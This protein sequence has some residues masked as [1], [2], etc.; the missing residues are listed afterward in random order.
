MLEGLE[1]T[2]EDR[3]LLPDWAREALRTSGWLDGPGGS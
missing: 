1:P 2:P 3:A